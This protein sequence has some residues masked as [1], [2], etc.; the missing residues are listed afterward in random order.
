MFIERV[1][2]K[3]IIIYAKS[4]QSTSIPE[5]ISKPGKPTNVCKRNHRLET[6]HTQFALFFYL[7]IDLL[8]LI[9]N[10]SIIIFNSNFTSYPMW[11]SFI[12][13]VTPANEKEKKF[14]GNIH[15]VRMLMSFQIYYTFT[16]YYIHHKFITFQ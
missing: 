12:I 7:S 4:T 15:V 11:I 8:L 16:I 9:A 5:T 2:Q 3:Q 13:D 1:G 6:T 10:Q 14:Y